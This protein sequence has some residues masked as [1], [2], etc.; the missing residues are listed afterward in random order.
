M[1][2]EW[3][4]RVVFGIYLSLLVHNKTFLYFSYNQMYQSRRSLWNEKIIDKKYIALV[5]GY[6]PESCRCE[7]PLKTDRGNA[8]EAITEFKLLKTFESPLPF[9]KYPA[10]RYS[11]VEAS[12]LTGRTHQI[13]RHLAHLRHYLIGDT[14]HGETRLN[15]FFKDAY[16]LPQMFLHAKEINF[17]K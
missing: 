17:V 7:E 4:F 1:I 5:R 13:R 14:A 12:P 16:G 6:F 8:Q 15:K 3:H 10:S 9:G 11:L 2:F